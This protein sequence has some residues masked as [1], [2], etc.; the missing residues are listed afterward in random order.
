MIEYQRFGI[1]FLPFSYEFEHKFS[2]KDALIERRVKELSLSVENA[3]Y[4]N[5]SFEKFASNFFA[6]IFEFRILSLRWF[7]DKK[8]GV[9]DLTSVFKEF[10][11]ILEQAKANPSM[12]ELIDNTNF[13]IRTNL[14]VVDKL[15]KAIPNFD[16][17]EDSLS[18][19]VSILSSLTYESTLYSL[20][21]SVPPTDY[22]KIVNWLN[23]S[24]LL[25]ISLITCFFILEKDLKVSKSKINQLSKM[26]SKS[27]QEY[28]ASAMQ[29]GIFDAKTYN[30]EINNFSDEVIHSEK[31]LSEQGVL[32][33]ASIL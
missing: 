6:Q 3:L 11:E 25:E 15:S 26:I 29:L 23:S 21:V 32:D 16:S 1:G 9:D 24:L 33:F 7:V 22:D 14:R 27:A 2:K 17:F 13:A 19:N 4:S 18:N 5:Q 30:L 10:E 12:S 20:F 8:L 28:G 31:L